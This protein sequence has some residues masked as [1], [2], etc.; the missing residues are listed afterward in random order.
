MEFQDIQ[1]STEQGFIL[2]DT[3]NRGS[4]WQACSGFLPLESWVKYVSFFTDLLVAGVRPIL[5]PKTS[6]SHLFIT[7]IKHHNEGYF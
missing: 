7:V 5:V 4:L 1:E 3:S 6:I 2:C